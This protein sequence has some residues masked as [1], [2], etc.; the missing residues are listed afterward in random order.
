MKKI[1]LYI[2]VAIVIVSC[3]VSIYYVVRNDEYIYATMATDINN[4]INEGETLSIP[5]VHEKKN[6]KTTL[7]VQC[8]SSILEID[9]ENWTIKAVQPGTAKLT[10]TSSNTK[11]GPF[12]FIFTVGNGSV[13]NPYYIRN[14]DDLR[15]IGKSWGL[16]ENYELVNDIDMSDEVFT[17]IGSAETPFNGNFSGGESY[18]SINN[19]VID[20]SADNSEPVGLFASNGE[21]GKIEN[22]TIKNA[23]V[24][25]KSVFSGIVAGKNYGLIGKVVL[26]DCSIQTESKENI[27]S[28]LI[29]GLNETKNSNARVSLCTVNGSIFSSYISGGLVGYN[30]GGVIDNNYVVLKNVESVGNEKTALFGGIAGFIREGDNEPKSS[31]II[32]NIVMFENIIK[33]DAVVSGVFGKTVAGSVEARGYYSMLI[34]NA[35]EALTPVGTNI[36][37]SELTSN[38][39]DTINRSINATKTEIVTKETYGSSW[40]FK[41][42]WK[43]EVGK[44]IK[45]NYSNE[46]FDY[47][48]LP[49]TGSIVEISDKKTLVAAIE[50]IRANPSANITYKIM[51]ES[52]VKEVKDENDE[53]VDKIIE[54][55][56]YSYTVDGDWTPIGTKEEPFA[57]KIIADKD[58]T[59]TIK[60]ANIEGTYAGLF[61]FVSKDAYISNINVVSSTFT[62]TMIGGIAGHNSGAKIENCKVSNSTFI[63]TKYAGGI[64]GYSEG[65]IE[66]C[67]IDNI[68]INVNEEKEKNIY[69]GGLVGKTTGIINNSKTE[70]VAVKVNFESEDNTIC[71]GGLAGHV[72]GSKINNSAALQFTAES[73]RY[74][75]RTYAGGIAGYSINSEIN[76]CGVA[77][78]CNININIEKSTS[79]VGGALGFMDGGRVY[80]TAISGSVLKG[81]ASAGVVSFCMGEIRECYVGTS[82]NLEGKYVGGLSVNFYGKANNS[83]SICIL[84]GTEVSA[85]LV[86]YLWKGSEVTNC[87]TYCSYSEGG[88]SYADTFSNYKAKEDDFGKINN[89]IIVGNNNQTLA[90]PEITSPLEWVQAFII[91]KDGQ[92]K[93]HVFVTFFG[94]KENFILENALVG[95][96][97]YQLFKDL[98]FD[99]N[100]WLYGDTTLGTAPVLKDVYDLGE[101]ASGTIVKEK[102]EDQNENEDDNTETPSEEVA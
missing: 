36:N 85:G 81:Y 99:T 14:E 56:T 20:M 72:N 64:V 49:I 16:N 27:Y 2:V 62:G 63:T 37:D 86:T 71:L 3:G 44:S 76:K 39:D 84:K 1:L 35:S 26:E 8:E 7:E 77:E 75:G 9:T 60:K 41:N 34:Y 83:Y 96:D 51:G 80:Q 90:K 43:I 91:S 67:Y 89:T 68:K 32:N 70:R 28:G 87:Y 57:G 52:T 102:E 61:A 59:I 94:N 40:D 65:T 30:K 47:Q 25:S 12:N 88:E 42:I 6:E 79:I 29:C 100:I 21:K 95:D 73:Y 92:T 10:V 38:D 48:I 19:L 33:K 13:E 54:E 74:L 46:K 15:K 5:V 53:V 22:L 78:S 17:P 101:S 58:A 18:Y 98:D 66:N 31:M 55:L 50:N 4:Y 93:V 82:V 45:L 97:Y 24:I 69:L 11:F 23:S